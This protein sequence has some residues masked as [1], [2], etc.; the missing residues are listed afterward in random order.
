MNLRRGDEYCSRIK[1]I[2]EYRRRYRN[3]WW[4]GL[5]G[6]EDNEWWENRIREKED[7]LKKSGEG[8]GGWK[9]REEKGMREVYE[10][11]DVW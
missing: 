3:V 8:N 6:K 11:R 9:Y 1:E 2:D 7:E 10:F 4:K 5:N